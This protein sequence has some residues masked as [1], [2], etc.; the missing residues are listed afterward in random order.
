[1]AA[2]LTLAIPSKGRLQ[3]QVHAYFADAGITMKKAAGARGYRAT[4]SGFPD[5]DVMLLSASE[6]AGWLACRAMCISAS[7]ARI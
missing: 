1:M 4:L 5:I 7:R 2:S 3:E 6:I